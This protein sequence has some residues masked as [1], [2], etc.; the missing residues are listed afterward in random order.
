[1]SFLQDKTENFVCVI[2][3]HALQETRQFLRGK[4]LCA[5]FGNASSLILKRSL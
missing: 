5:I 2:P 4:W 3:A 1:M